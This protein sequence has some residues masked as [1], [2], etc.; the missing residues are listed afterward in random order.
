MNTTFQKLLAVTMLAG[1]VLHADSSTNKTAMNYRS[2]G[3]NLAR[4]Y[5]T[6]WHRQLHRPKRHDSW[7]SEVQA[8]LYYEDSTNG[9]S[10]GKYFGFDGRRQLNVGEGCSDCVDIDRA[11]FVHDCKCNECDDGNTECAECRLQGTIKLSGTRDAWGVELSYYQNL[12]CLFDGFYFLLNAP[13]NREEN[14][15]KLRRNKAECCNSCQCN[16]CEC[17][18]ACTSGCNSCSSKSNSSCGSCSS[19][20]TGCPQNCEKKCDELC[21]VK[22]C[23]TKCGCEATV[24]IADYFAGNIVQ[25]SPNSQAALTRAR[26]RGD[27]SQTELGDLDFLVGWDFY[28]E[29]DAHVGINAAVTFPTSSDAGSRNAFEPRAGNGDHWGLGAGATASFTPWSDDDQELEIIFAANYRYLF[30]GEE[31]RVLGVKGQNWG[32]YMLVGTVNCVGV[33]PAA[34]VLATKVDV[35]PGSEIDALVGLAY[36]WNDWTFDIGYNIYARETEDVDLKKNSWCDCTY[37]FAGKDY[38]ADRSM[39]CFTEADIAKCDH[40]ICCAQCS[41]G[42]AGPFINR[43]DLDTSVAETPSF[44]THKLYGGVGYTTTD[45]EYPVQFKVG[46]F[47]EWASS[48]KSP[49]NWSIFGGVALSY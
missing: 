17:G 43:C 49:E 20:T 13:I 1:S 26:I 11:H 3:R 41:D 47:Y 28:R 8:T 27:Q 15:L 23:I 31:R 37:G 35:T 14:H 9:S 6:T 36:T 34:N 21:E 29:D 38:C 44:A 32:H 16:P 39:P 33:Q 48:R 25:D 2:V 12:D 24:G 46:A 18:S 22:Q 42:D 19:C 10:I 4:Q 5:G 30:E 40:A 45:W 7:G